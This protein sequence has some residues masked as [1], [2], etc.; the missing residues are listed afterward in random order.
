M[1]SGW[2]E[3]LDR[4]ADQDVAC[5]VVAGYRNGD[6]L[7]GSFSAYQRSTS[8]GGVQLSFGDPGGTGFSHY[9]Y[10]CTIPPMTPNGASHVVTYQATESNEIQ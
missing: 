4:H 5:R 7:T 9:Y 2:I 6:V 3:V 1:Y 10:F 8:I